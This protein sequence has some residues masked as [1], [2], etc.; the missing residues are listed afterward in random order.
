[1][2]LKEY[3]RIFKRHRWWIVGW[4]LLITAGYIFY[5]NHIKH[6]KFVSRATFVIDS[7]KQAG[8]AAKSEDV[9]KTMEDDVKIYRPLADME[10]RKAIMLQDQVIQEAF[11]KYLRRAKDNPDLNTPGEHSLT[12]KPYPIFENDDPNNDKNIKLFRECVYPVANSINY[13]ITLKAEGTN[14]HKARWLLESLIEAYREKEEMDAQKTIKALIR[15]NE[16]RLSQIR[17]L[18][19]ATREDR[20]IHLNDLNKRH[21]GR[22]IWEKGTELKEAERQQAQEKLNEVSNELLKVESALQELE[23]VDPDRLLVLED[24]SK[25]GDLLNTLYEQK[26]KL[27]QDL[28]QLRQD[29]TDKHPRVVNKLVELNS[30]EEQFPKLAKEILDKEKRELSRKRADLKNM[31]KRLLEEL[32]RVNHVIEIIQENKVKFEEFDVKIERYNDSVTRLEQGNEMMQEELIKIKTVDPFEETIKPQDGMPEDLTPNLLYYIMVIGA[33]LGMAFAYILE[34]MDDTIRTAHDVE[35]FVG[36]R[37]IGTVPMLGKGEE[38]LL[39]RIALKS[40]I[41]EMMNTLS[42]ILQSWMLKMKGQAMLIV[43]S[44]PGEGKS[45]FITNLAVALCRGGEKVVLIDSDLRK[46]SLH[47]FFGVD[48]SVGLSNYLEDAFPDD[49][50]PTDEAKIAKIVHHT[51]VEGLFIIPSGAI[52]SNPVGLLKGENVER[53]INHLKTYIGVILIDTPP[54][55]MIDAGVLATK[56]DA[57]VTVM[58]AGKVT[59]REALAGK[60]LIENVGGN[61]IGVILNKVTLEGEEYYYYFE[62]YSYYYGSSRSRK[63]KPV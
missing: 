59:K 3:V 62:G 13:S 45:T 16:E 40:P 20:K 30:L 50:E 61:N 43:S 1:M 8:S 35:K 32:D 7:L 10:Q 33:M 51:D 4:F 21:G 29:F 18:L 25:V 42:M 57:V 48:N 46:P 49:V 24:K 38:K 47:R 56:V 37:V 55:A 28:A 31:A 52:P 54:L 14:K 12:Q 11:S 27:Q 9:T 26:I 44:K 23:S 17:E 2:G 36:L 22:V 19:S 15:Q 6:K 63:K 58:D 53:L 60:H 5:E 41:S 34:Y 39:H